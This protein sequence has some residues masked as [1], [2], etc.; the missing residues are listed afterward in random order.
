MF[1]RNAWYLAG[2]TSQLD[3]TPLVAITIIGEPV[4]IYRGD[5]GQIV[6]L[7]D[8]CVHRMAPLSLGRI[9][10]NN[11]RCMYHGLL[12]DQAGKT[13][14]IPGQDSIP[15]KAC[16]KRFA[17]QI[18]SGWIWVWMGKAEEADL[19]WLPPVQGFTNPE[20]MLRGGSLD[21]DAGYE[22]IN[23]NLTDLG[24]LAWVHVAS[25][26]ADKTWTETLADVSPLPNGVRINRWLRNIAPIPPLGGAAALSTCDQW[27][28]LDYYIPG[29][30]SFYN[31]VYPAGT[32]ERYAG[33]E[34]DK[35]DP[36]MV[37]EHYTQQAVTPMTAR[38]TRYFF[39]WGPSALHGNEESA[40]IM[41]G[42]MYLAFGEDKVII[43]GQQKIIDADPTRQPMPTVHDKGVV[44]FQ[45]LMHK[46]IREQGEAH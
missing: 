22:L 10:G 2:P 17:V 3:T 38:T 21:Y 33:G 16:V 35:A 12:F 45:R 46:L 6:A 36:T 31:A 28:Q 9:E 19:D 7:E 13:I 43:E 29:V 24:H 25:F 37:F 23:N 40:A 32:A 1:L 5:N 20:W 44:L 18:Q 8:R 14:E 26:G 11:L 4:V 42:A 15:P 41:E 34:P 39:T 30:F 27:A